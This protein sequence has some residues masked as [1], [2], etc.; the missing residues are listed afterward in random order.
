MISRDLIA[1]VHRLYRFFCSVLRLG[2]ICNDSLVGECTGVRNMCHLHKM[3]IGLYRFLF[4]QLQTLAT[5]RSKIEKI[6][7]KLYI[8][9]VQ[10]FCLQTLSLLLCVDLLS[11]NVT[12]QAEHTALT[13]LRTDFYIFFRI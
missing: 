10:E 6:H 2:C 11:R 12:K 13:D 1:S 3:L 8:G 5:D 4:L 7:D 9:K